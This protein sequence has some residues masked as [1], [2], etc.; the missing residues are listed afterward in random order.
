M[1][2]SATPSHPTCPPFSVLLVVGCVWFA[3][4][5]G[6]S[7]AARAEA[8]VDF[9]RQIRSI[10]AENC[11]HCHGP[12]AGNR[13]ADLR[14]DTPDGAAT[15]IA[16]GDRHASELFR[17]LTSADPAEL[18]PPPDSN[19]RLTPAQVELLGRWIDQ[20]A[21]WQEHWSFAPLVRPPLPA[22][23]EDHASNA[24]DRFV[25]AAWATEGILGSELASPEARLRRVTLDLT[26]LPP[27]LED[28]DAFLAD[29]SKEAYERAVER[30]LQS[31]A[32]GE[33]MAWDWLDAARYAD[34]NGYQGDGE[35]TMW[36]W[37][38]W[39]VD[40]FN[41]NLP[42]DQF[43]LWQ[44]AGDQL[45]D[46]TFEQRL[47][48]GFFRNHMI[49]GEGG[50]I[51]EE[52]RI[53][54]V[55]D[56]TEALGTVWLGLTL[57]CCRCHDHK[58]DPLTQADYY[59][60]FAFFNQTPI[61]GG[62]GNPQTPPVL[63][64]PAESQRLEI[65][66]LQQELAAVR[67]RLAERSKALEAEQPAWEQEW[68]AKLDQPGAWKPLLPT[69][70]VAA[71]QDI[72]LLED[73]S[74][75]TSGANPPQDSY[76]LTYRPSPMRA[77]GLRLE[78][79][80]HESMTAGGLARSDSGNFVLTGLEIE[81]QRPGM[82]LRKI[83]IA[84]GEASFEQ[85]GFGI[86]G[87]WDN[88]PNTG[89]AVYEGRPIDRDHQAVLRFAAPVDVMEGDEWVITLRHQSPHAQHNIGRLRL[90]VT[91]L[92]QPTLGEAAQESLLA[93]LRVPAETR[94]ENQRKLIR[95]SQRESDT[96][97]RELAAQVD[98]VDKRLAAVRGSVPKVMIMGDQPERRPTFILQV[99]AYTK[100]GAEVSAAV[101]GFLPDLP[102]GA[103]A[104]RL[105]LA[106]WLID[107]SQPL[108]ARV[109][110]NRFWQ[111][112][113]G[114]GLV[115]TPEDFGVQGEIPRHRELLDWLAAD[116][117]D[118]GWDVKRLLRQIVT[119]EVYQQDSR[120]TPET[121]ERDPENRLLARGPRRRLPSWMIRDQALAI[122]GLLVP[123]LGGQPVN[124]YQPAG[125]WEEATFGNKKYTQDKGEAL[126]RRTLY[127]F[128]RRIVAPTM[129]FD[130]A[131]RQTCTVSPFLTNTPLHA[132]TTLNDTTY[133]EAARG[134][135]Q[136]V[137]THRARL[138]GGSADGA[139]SPEPGAAALTAADRA[140][141]AWG[142]RLATSR[143]PRDAEVDILLERLGILRTQFSDAAD[144][145][146]ALL[147]IGESPRG[148][149]WEPREQAAWTGICSL[150]LNLDETITKP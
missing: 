124:G 70:Y 75:L 79:L 130:N 25:R 10:L 115:K 36:P 110:V 139:A 13:Q 63:E 87:V 3:G 48:S 28:L 37:R 107:D 17:R 65:D 68:L 32:F 82:E 33:R 56:M 5:V 38:D 135:S 91:E 59:S 54:Y 8:P 108:M 20:G 51:A 90:A 22:G 113:F 62:G 7:A 125:I 137:L 114:I 73:G 26:G 16:A 6:T 117:R 121:H 111:S 126:Y 44:V 14:L 116:F 83:E 1:A 72:T 76:T 43:T 140:A 145:A 74:L 123:K 4:W 46:A 142:F 49:N 58:F 9:A 129:L 119:S 120:V 150:I 60:L 112:L 34:S 88:D 138:L 11:F 40:A 109:V 122:G 136:R 149:A 141:L 15:M 86:G 148:D 147:A 103:P 18:M 39:V 2:A 85:G 66:R 42:F 132:L 31:P 30:L 144:A 105:G 101:P 67:E 118:S 27:T 128:W 55:F 106:R 97:H 84:S 93:A 95:R 146:N 24:I 99:G 100:P 134:M 80:R 21:A 64:V 92:P 94:D 57:N 143:Q 89:W 41:R 35:R 47:A 133:V 19:R 77:T 81:V 23:A 71:G 98:A 29:P 69:G 78:A 53:E 50:R 61:N 131:T 45:P 104:N 102:E 96:S 127:T 12:D 52:N